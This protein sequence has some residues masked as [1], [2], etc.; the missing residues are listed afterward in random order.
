MFLN[1]MLATCTDKK[2]LV[3]CH[4]SAYIFY[5]AVKIG[6]FSHYFT[7]WHH[8]TVHSR[9]FRSVYNKDI[10]QKLMDVSFI[11]LISMIVQHAKVKFMRF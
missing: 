8:D 6:A 4:Q 7:V 2:R 10:V 3:N 5:D 11:N 1:H 9:G